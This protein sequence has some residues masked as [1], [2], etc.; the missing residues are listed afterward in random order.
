MLNFQKFKARLL[1]RCNQKKP[2]NEQ[3]YKIH[4]NGGRPFKCVIDNKNIRIYNNYDKD[5]DPFL[6]FQFEKIFIGKSPLSELTDFSEGYGPDFDGNSILL[7]LNQKMYVFIG[8]CIYSFEA[9]NEIVDYL[10]PVGNNDVPYP[11]AIDCDQNYYLMIENMII[12]NN[13]EIQKYMEN[14][15]HDPSMYYY[16]N[17]LIHQIPTYPCP[18]KEFLVGKKSYIFNYNHLP[19]EN[20]ESITNNG[21]KQVKIIF[22]NNDELNID[23]NKYIE[24][25]ELVGQDKNFETIK[26]GYMIQ[27]RL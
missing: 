18:I 15:N 12:K 23:E 8:I 11:Y 17:C 16:D 21:K 10:S 6:Q 13:Q 3:I 22:E 24:I 19:K 25:M 1:N 7:K 20:Y 9:I 2:T 14:K 5:K 26:N 4:D 27:E